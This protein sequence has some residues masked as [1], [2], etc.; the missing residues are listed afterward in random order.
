MKHV[1]T[2]IVNFD[3]Q[4]KRILRYADASLKA[5]RLSVGYAFPQTLYQNLEANYGQYVTLL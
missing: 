1:G 5:K 2:S 3:V 4:L